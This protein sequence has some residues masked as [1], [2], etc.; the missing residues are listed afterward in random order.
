MSTATPP[1][2]ARGSVPLA[3]V[4]PGGNRLRPVRVRPEGWSWRLPTAWPLIAVFLLYPL[5]WVLGVSSFVF[6]IFAVPMVAQMRKRGPVR[7]PP[8]F[9]IWMVLLLWVF[10]SVLT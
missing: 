4:S 10:L 3:A 1:R 6:V 8:G 9:G 2:T 7:V 5:W